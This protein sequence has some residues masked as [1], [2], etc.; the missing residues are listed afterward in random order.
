M[1]DDAKKN[2]LAADADSLSGVPRFPQFSPSQQCESAAHVEGHDDGNNEQD[3]L[4]SPSQSS[5]QGQLILP[6]S[7]SESPS[8]RGLFAAMLSDDMDCVQK[9]LS[10]AGLDEPVDDEKQLQA[11][12]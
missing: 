9:R 10:F 2:E 11:T 6:F 4:E 7:P 12:P 3:I 8:K 1:V 5:R